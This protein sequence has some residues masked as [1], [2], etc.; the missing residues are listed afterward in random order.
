MSPF[1]EADLYNAGKPE[2][3][4]ILKR[5]LKPLDDLY[6]TTSEQ[7]IFLDKTRNLFDAS[8]DCS[9]AGPV[10]IAVH[11]SYDSTNML[12]ALLS[13]GLDPDMQ[14]KDAVCRP[15]H[16]CCKLGLLGAARC[17]FLCRPDLQAKN[18]DSC[19]PLMVAQ[20]TACKVS[21]IFRLSMCTVHPLYK[22]S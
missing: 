7:L 17:I 6:V 10:F 9:G 16:A 4:F 8:V 14:C 20:M 5:V 22:P 13:A 3:W 21:Q 19:T 2:H 15:S 12:K 18:A 11:H 1:T